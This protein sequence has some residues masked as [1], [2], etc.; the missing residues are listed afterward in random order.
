MQGP[1]VGTYVQIHG[2]SKGP[3]EGPHVVKRLAHMPIF[4]ANL[5]NFCLR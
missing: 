3:A 4:G 5:R 2:I 1:A